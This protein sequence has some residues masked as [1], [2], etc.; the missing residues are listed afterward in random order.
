MSF[1]KRL[2]GRSRPPARTPQRPT[3]PPADPDLERRLFALCKVEPGIELERCI[4]PAQFLSLAKKYRL[5]IGDSEAEARVALNFRTQDEFF[6]VQGLVRRVLRESEDLHLLVLDL[7][8]E[9]AMQNIRW[10]EVH[11]HWPSYRSHG[12]EAESVAKAV[13]EAAADAE[14]RH[15]V[16]LGWFLDLRAGDD[17]GAT[18][19]VL[20]W[21]EGDERV[22]GIHLVGEGPSVDLEDLAEQCDQRG[23]RRTALAESVTQA[24]GFLE[25][26]QPHR[27][28]LDGPAATSE[29][30]EM[31]EGRELGAVLRPVSDLR[32]GHHKTLA[33][34]PL[35][36]FEDRP[37]LLL[38]TGGAPLFGTNLT[39][40]YVG[41]HRAL[42]VGFEA[43][44]S[45]AAKGVRHSFLD[46]E[47]KAALEEE[48][49]G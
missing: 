22:L 6:E 13:N 30:L 15:S 32:L 33:E 10:S 3:L 24:R 45:L 27:M 26:W 2:F 8:A 47:I 29:I 42:G 44:R 25:R 9:Q 40:E 5:P 23:L 12:M 34:H 7:L 4:R 35:A 1:L 31:L 17:A 18:E 46:P 49:G 19:E 41:L 48:I 16:Q 21:A 38:S 20:A 39:R 43:L 28:V 36:T 11:L 37:G 14:R